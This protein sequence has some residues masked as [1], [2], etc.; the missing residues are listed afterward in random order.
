MKQVILPSGMKCS[1][2]LLKKVY[3]SKRELRAY[4]EIYKIVSRLDPNA[5]SLDAIWE[6]N[7]LIV[8]SVIPSDLAIY[9][10]EIHPDYV[11]K[12]AK[13]K[14]ALRNVKIYDN[15]GTSVKNGTIDRYTAAYT[16]WEGAKEYYCVMRAMSSEPFHPQGFGQM[17]EGMTGSHLGKRIKF[18]DLPQPCQELILQDRTQP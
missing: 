8:S 7:P 12:E 4:D 13:I 14:K 5:M 15:G 10:P 18:A 1:P 3:K 16:D 6:E 9:N 17:C 11:S 2:M